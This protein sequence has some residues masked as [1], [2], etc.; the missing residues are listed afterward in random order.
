ML[1]FVRGGSSI[2]ES[3]KGICRIVVFLTWGYICCCSPIFF[4][5]PTHLIVLPRLEF[6]H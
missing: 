2:G 4:V 3:K 6:S 5:Q 1:A